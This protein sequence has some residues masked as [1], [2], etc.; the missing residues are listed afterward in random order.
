M[1]APE[2]P[3][4]WVWLARIRRPQGRKGEVFAELL[5]D[6]PD[7]F[8]ERRRLWLIASDDLV[9][10][11]GAPGPSHSGTRDTEPVDPQLA[12]QSS[13]TTGCTKAAS[14]STSPES[15]PSPPPRPSKA[16]SSPS[17]ARSDPHSPK[18][19]PTS[20]TSSAARLLMSQAATPSPSAQSRK[21]T[22]PEAPRRCSSSATRVAKSSSPSPKVISAAS[23]STR[24]V[25]KWLCPKVSP[26][27]TLPN[28]CARQPRAL[29]PPNPPT[30][31]PHQLTFRRSDAPRLATR[32]QSFLLMIAR[33]RWPQSRVAFPL[34]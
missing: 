33:A 8:A 1:T 7:K 5:T 13:P 23:T 31:L 18:T 22:A 12:R 21:S 15:I 26:I 19:R 27:S 29:A 6:F 28:K 10:K 3:A 16:S 9:R 17:P 4:D 2:S 25:S 30:P 32:H 24:S 14:S 20:A 11:A 34:H